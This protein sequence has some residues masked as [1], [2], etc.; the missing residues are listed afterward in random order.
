[1]SDQPVL[2]LDAVFRT[3]KQAEAP[4]EVIR[5]ASL[6]VPAGE[7]VGL[8]GP[9]GAGKSTLLH[10]AGLLELPDG[11]DVRIAF[12]FPADSHP[13]ITYPVAL[14]AGPQRAAAAELLAFLQ[15]PEARG[16][17]SDCWSW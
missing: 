13:A 17:F 3:Y 12:R 8:I 10:V 1:M 15:G 6:Q 5:G 7:L 2:E 4:L 11:G 16:L 9:S 14:V